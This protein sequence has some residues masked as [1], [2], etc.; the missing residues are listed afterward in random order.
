MAVDVVARLLEWAERIP[1]APAVIARGQSVSYAEFASLARRFAA[2]FAGAGE[3]PRVLIDAP[4]GAPAYAAMFGCLMAGGFYAPVNQAA[5]AE[6]QELVIGSFEPDFVVTDRPGDARYRG[7]APERLID[8]AQ[9]GS[10]EAAE[11]REP[12][13][14]AYVMYTSGSTGRPKGVMIP[15]TGLSHYAAWAVDAVGFAPGERCTQHPNIGFDL[16]VIEIFGALCGGAALAPFVTARD[17]SLPALAVRDL[18]LTLWVSVPSV[19]DVIRAGR[20]ADARHLGSLRRM[21]F[22]GE[23][24]LGTHLETIF[25]ALPDVEV[26]NAYGPTEATVSMTELRLTAANYREAVRNSVALGD[27]IPGMGLD[28]VGGDENEGEIVISGPQ[29]AAG[30]WR[31]PERTAAAFRAG[32]R[33]RSYYTGDWA[34]R[35]GA[36]LYFVNRIDRQV[37]VQGFRLELDEVDAALRECGVPEAVTVLAGGHLISFV[38]GV[39]ELDVRAVQHALAQ[40]L[41]HYAIPREIR[42]LAQLPRGA[43]DKIDVAELIKR[44]Q[45]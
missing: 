14:L 45:G 36:H 39:A 38:T 22:C 44:A 43:N 8:P 13:E 37:K 19:V 40:K 16:S 33:G 9:P 27:A 3:H 6:R 2:A 23:P 5:P 20:Q 31:D 17:R 10:T 18:E 26:I 34:R 4:Q 24:L 7:L 42:V 1:G 30:Y 35:S 32:P 25:A 29:L 28:L 15:R 11:P 21:F 12:H 41:P